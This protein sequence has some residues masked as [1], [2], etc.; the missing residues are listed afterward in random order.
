M[1]DWMVVMVMVRMVR[2]M[3]KGIE[4]IETA[5]A[6]RVEVGCA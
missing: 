5:Q 6:G 1:M 2:M 4:F 3:M